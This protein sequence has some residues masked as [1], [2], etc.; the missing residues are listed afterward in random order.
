VSFSTARARGQRCSWPHDQGY[1]PSRFVC[2]RLAIITHISIELGRREACS[3][4]RHAGEGEMR[5]C[6]CTQQLQC[7]SS[8]RLQ[9]A[10]GEVPPTQVL[11]PC[12][13]QH[14]CDT[15]GGKDHGWI[16]WCV[17]IDW[18]A[19]LMLAFK[20]MKLWRVS[21]LKLEM[22]RSCSIVR[23]NVKNMGQGL[24]LQQSIHQQTTSNQTV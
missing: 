14:R 3:S 23:K 20:L 8:M 2:T 13:R 15:A 18:P 12:R 16:L 5:Q 11:L 10:R 1:P 24:T 22:Q 6:E 9:V 7:A 21:Q 19:A 17:H 4:G